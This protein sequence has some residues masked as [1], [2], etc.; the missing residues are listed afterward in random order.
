MYVYF[1]SQV[2]TLSTVITS[3]AV[4]EIV[5]TCVYLLIKASKHLLNVFSEKDVKRICILG[6][7]LVGCAGLLVTSNGI[8]LLTSCSVHQ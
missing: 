6:Y 3:R 7:I 1:F 4:V 8:L 5:V 2:C